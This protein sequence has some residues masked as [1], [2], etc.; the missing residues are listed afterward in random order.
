MGNVQYDFKNKLVM[1][2]AGGKGIGRAIVDSFLECGA[3]V[4]SFSRSIEETRQDN[5][6]LMK[7]DINDH[8]FLESFHREV[9]DHFSD[10]PYVK[11]Q[12]CVYGLFSPSG[13]VNLVFLCISSYLSVR[14][15]MESIVCSTFCWVKQ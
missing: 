9:V 15:E 2:S 13:N 7:G 3:M 1:V 12:G 8:N 11:R 10:H 14:I 4:A 5:L 6:L